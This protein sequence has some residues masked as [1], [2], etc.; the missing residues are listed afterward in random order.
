MLKPLFTGLLFKQLWHWWR[1]GLSWSIIMFLFLFTDSLNSASGQSKL[2]WWPR[3]S[4]WLQRCHENWGAFHPWGDK[5]KIHVM[6]R[7]KDHDRYHKASEFCSDIFLTV[8]LSL[9]RLT[10]PF[11]LS[12]VRGFSILSL[13]YFRDPVDHLSFVVLDGGPLVGA[14]WLY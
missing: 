10:S 4:P 13:C 7:R 6:R 5:E 8:T 2:L 11:F 1:D 12:H 14:L 9:F 3:N